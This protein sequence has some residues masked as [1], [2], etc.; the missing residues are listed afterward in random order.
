MLLLRPLPLDTLDARD[1]NNALA[2][3]GQ[4]PASTPT[5]F[6]TGP[7]FVA[8]QFPLTPR[9]AAVRTL[10]EKKGPSS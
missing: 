6:L 7:T 2:R 1:F 9:Q 3:L 5:L 4:G 8:V 10:A